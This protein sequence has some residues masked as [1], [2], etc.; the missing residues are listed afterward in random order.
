MN[1]TIRVPTTT[2]FF[3]SMQ[4]D[5]QTSTKD[6]AVAG[7]V[8]EKN[9]ERFVLEGINVTVHQFSTESNHTRTP[10]KLTRKKRA[11][12][13]SFNPSTHILTT[14]LVLFLKSKLSR[15]P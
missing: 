9:L 4:F 15:R 8:N 11:V 6:A 3:V 13:F 12:F 10:T 2:R 7:Q 5:A 14:F 1:P